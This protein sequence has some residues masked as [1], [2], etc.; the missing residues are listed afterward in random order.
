MSSPF[1][2]S[3]LG[4]LRMSAMIIVIGVIGIFL[5]GVIADEE[6]PWNIAVFLAIGMVLSSLLNAWLDTKR[7]ENRSHE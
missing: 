5:Y 4:N 6:I 7:Q 3:L 1:V 2:R